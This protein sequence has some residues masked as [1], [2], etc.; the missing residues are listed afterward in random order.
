MAR[1]TAN[2]L[3]ELWKKANIPA[4]APKD[5]S[6]RLLNVYQQYR[7]LLKDKHSSRPIHVKRR[8]DF[9]AKLD[10]LFDI[11]LKNAM[12][13]IDI[14][15]DRLFYISMRG[16]RK[17]YM[18]GLDRKWVMKQ[19]KKRKR[20]LAL[21]KAKERSEIEKQ[22]LQL[23]RQLSLEASSGASTAESDTDEGM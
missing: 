11:G 6:E 10:R 20:Q 22:T 12:E 9:I 3:C 14:E 23:T 16:D 19:E 17:G 13:L 4:L 8:E 2:E 18:G 15:E 7:S 21:L 1:E 5:A